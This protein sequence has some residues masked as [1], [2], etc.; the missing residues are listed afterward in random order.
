MEYKIFHILFFLEGERERE[1]NLNGWSFI[2]SDERSKLFLFIDP[3][4][5]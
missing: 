1:K 3:V 2:I 5:S 4:Q